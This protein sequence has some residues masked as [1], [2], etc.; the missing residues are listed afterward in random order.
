MMY[1]VLGTTGLHVSRICL[2]TMTFG[3]P[4]SP[5]DC[6]RLVAQAL[7]RGLN[8]FDTANIYEGYNRTFGSSGGVSETILGKALDGR[9]DEAV[10]CTKFGA[11]VGA[12]AFDAG[13]SAKHLET[14][15]EASLRRL[16]TDH[17]DLVLAH[18]WDATAAV[19][20]VWR[21]FDRWVRSGKVLF[22]GV[23]NWPSWRIAQAA[24]IARHNAWPEITAMSPKLSLLCRQPE[25]EHLPCAE[26]YK[27][28]V[29]P[30][31]PL[32]GGLLTGRYQRGGKPPEGTRMAEKPDWTTTPDEA[33][34]N[35]LEAL[36]RLASEANVP[37]AV[38]SL[39]WVLSRRAVTSVIAGCRSAEQLED[40]VASTQFT[41]PTEHFAELDRLF[42]PPDPAGA[43]VLAWSDG[44]KLRNLE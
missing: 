22:T 8:F 19:E 24:E 26:Q 37:V 21:V 7:D 20:T 36:G 12:G 41:I 33:G 5:P 10:I 14:Q 44:W 18:R 11:P 29:L 2:G 6:E 30:Y 42:P 34:W 35:R 27:I 9:R 15:L 16:R 4:L 40:L 31:Q 39:A 23:S 43:A 38:Y 17:V 32:Q 25:L 28:A 3:S 13:L 1:S